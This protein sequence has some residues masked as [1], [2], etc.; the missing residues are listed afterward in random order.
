MSRALLNSETETGRFFAALAVTKIISV[1]KM[2]MHLTPLYLDQAVDIFKSDDEELDEDQE[3]M[4]NGHDLPASKPQPEVGSNDFV[5]QSQVDLLKSQAMAAKE[6][7]D[8]CKAINELIMFRLQENPIAENSYVQLSYLLA[9]RTTDPALRRHAKEMI[10]LMHENLRELHKTM[11]PLLHNFMA[12][13]VRG[14]TA[15]PN[16]EDEDS[17]STAP[18]TN[19]SDALDIQNIKRAYLPSILLAYNG[20]LAFASSIV[21]PEILLKSLELANLLADETV[22]PDLADA[23]VDA[24]RMEDMVESLALSQQRLIRMQQDAATVEKR[25]R[26][27]EERTGKGRGKSGVVRKKRSALSVKRR[28]W[29]GETLDLWDVTKG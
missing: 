13:P 2:S 22:N 25:A 11:R 8:I 20:A 6:M 1:E 15:S 16:E 12:T 14:T 21:G 5:Y 7:Q 24:G 26:R 4:L 3:D 9:N 27:E 18:F 29:K 23:V 10:A 28:E 19:P 17:T